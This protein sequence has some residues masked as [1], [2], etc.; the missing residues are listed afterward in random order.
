MRLAIASSIA[1]GVYK[2]FALEHGYWLIITVLVIV[3]PIF[4]DTRRRAVERVTGSVAG[5]IFAVIVAAFVRDLAVI[6]VLL[7]VFSVLAFS[8][9]RSNYGV[10]VFFLTPFVVLMIDT[11]V[12]GDWQIA[13]VRILN[14][15]VGGIIALAV[16]YLLRPRPSTRSQVPTASP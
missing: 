4:A 1:I 16:T 10:Y 5:G 6:D 11:V 13:L 3:K 7:V 15:I 12:P 9:V 2:Y 14:T 8:H